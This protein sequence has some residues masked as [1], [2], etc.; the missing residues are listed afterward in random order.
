MKGII[1]FVRISALCVGVIIALSCCAGGPEVMQV[2]DSDESLAML[3]SS[4]TL[5]QRIGQ[6]F[7]GWVPRGG[8]SEEI[9]D[10]LGAGEIGG[11]ILYRW[12]YD[13]IDDV[14]SLTLK[15]QSISATSHTGIPLFVAADQEGGRVA[16]FRFRE[17]VQLPAPFH[18]ALLGD[19]EAVEA[20]AYVNARQLR[21]IG[22][23]MNLA[24]VLDLYP[25]PDRT[26]IGDR[27]F[28]DDA[29]VSAA[30]GSAFVRGTLRADVLPVIKH[31]PGHGL[32]SVDSHGN[33]PVIESLDSDE[34]ERHVRPF[35]AA[36]EAGAPAVM[37]AHL[38][39]PAIDAEYPVTLSDVFIGG[40]LRDDLG[41]EGMVIS[42]GLSM[43]ALAKNYT[44][45]DTIARCFQV[46]IDAILVHSKYSV[47][48]LVGIVEG[49]VE[50]GV[51]TRR[52]IDEGLLRVLRAKRTAGL[53]N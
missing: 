4:L 30:M 3:L 1:P 17:F 8:I 6:R 36:I 9:E 43:G 33:L 16:A 38:L 27:S 11:F 5:R 31:Y 19:V 52:Q 26:I 44:L 40:L 2:P 24:P 42:D 13:T 47:Q 7:I 20:A 28:G 23:N 51:V 48:E 35:A 10:L 41:F 37:P 21:S 50:Q 15:L 25:L 18:L 46:G 22:I 32:S 14:R 49:M 39:F 29:T 12:N 45:E 53:L 34:L